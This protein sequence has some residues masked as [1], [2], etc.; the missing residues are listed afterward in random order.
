VPLKISGPVESPSVDLDS[1]KLV[2]RG[3]GQTVEQGL[4]SFVKQLFRK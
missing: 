4:G 1:A 2:Q 3:S